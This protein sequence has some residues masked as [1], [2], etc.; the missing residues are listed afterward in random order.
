MTRQ[1]SLYSLG[2]VRRFIAQGMF[3]LATHTCV[4]DVAELG[5]EREQVGTLLA[6][7]TEGHFR[8]VYG[9]CETSFGTF[10]ADDYVAWIDVETVSVVDQNVGQKID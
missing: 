5:L 2:D 10:D 7:L 4:E 1:A 6:Q 9:P 8:K 3:R